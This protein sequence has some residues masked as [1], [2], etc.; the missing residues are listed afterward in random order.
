MI[1]KKE[2]K[3]LL[4]AAGLLSVVLVYFF[5]VKPQKEERAELENTGETLVSELKQVKQYAENQTYYEQKTASMQQEIDAVLAQFPAWIT[6]EKTIMYADMLEDDTD[7]YIP[8]ISIGNSN[9]LYTLGQESGET[10]ETGISLYGTPVV[11]TF[12]VSYDD[13]KK[14]VRMIQENEEK[15]NIETLTVSY[16]GAGGNLVGTMTVN[17]YAVT[18]AGKEYVTPD[19][20][21]MILGTDNIFGTLSASG[22]DFDAV[23]RTKD[24]AQ[25][26]EDGE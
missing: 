17:M 6:E 11:Y 8:N 21:S 12:T 20:P 7:I 1:T 10:A 15:C 23:P 9:Y 24:E 4:Y 22:N 13:M 14:V 19:V 5:I 2:K 18:G 26:L 16:N 25:A 3:L